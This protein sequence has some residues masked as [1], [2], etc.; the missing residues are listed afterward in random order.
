M[1]ALKQV[2]GYDPAVIAGEEP[3]LCFRLRGA[4]WAVWRIDSP[5]TIHDADMHYARQWWMR[6]VRSGFGY[7]QVWQKTSRTER[8]GLY[9]RQ[10]ASAIGWTIGV[11]LVA[12]TLSIAFGPLAAAVAPLLWAIQLARLSLRGGR[13]WGWHMLIG[14]FAETIGILRFAAGRIGGKKQGA[15]FYK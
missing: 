4:G 12:L 6:A 15:I 10:V 11:A 5:M 1:P 14:K 7:A 3:E 13:I 9:G 8:Q 2:Q